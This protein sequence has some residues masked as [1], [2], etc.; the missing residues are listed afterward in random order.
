MTT[1]LQATASVTKPGSCLG[2]KQRSKPVCTSSVG[3]AT[4][5]NVFS[6]SFCFTVSRC[7]VVTLN[8]V[9]I[10]INGRFFL[11]TVVTFAA[12]ILWFDTIGTTIFL[13]FTGTAKVV[14]GHS[15]ATAAQQK[16][17]S[18]DDT[19]DRSTIT[20]IR[21]SFIIIRFWWFWYAFI[22]CHSC[23]WS[24]PWEELVGLNINSSSNNS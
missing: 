9:S 1:L 2:L 6:G 20:F 19:N 7:L 18:N 14:S 23:Y 8:R 4:P 16:D 11:A 22:F 12:T 3:T 21:F 17:N 13:R 5:S 15:T 24:L 10:F